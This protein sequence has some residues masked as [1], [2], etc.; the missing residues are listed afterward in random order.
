MGKTWDRG[1]TVSGKKFSRNIIDNFRAPT[2]SFYEAIITPVIHYYIGG[3]ECTM[4]AKCV[5]K[6]GKQIPGPH[7]VGEATAGLHDSNHLGGNS[8]LGHV[9]FGRVAGLPS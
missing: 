7:M 1:K 2:E 8:L 6:S 5:D 4:E 9:V 3:L